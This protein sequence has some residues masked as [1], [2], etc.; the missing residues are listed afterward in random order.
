MMNEDYSMSLFLPPIGPVREGGR[1]V[2]GASMVPEMTTGLEYVY[3]LIRYDEGL[4]RQTDAVRRAADAGNGKLCRCLKAATL[5]YVTPC[6]VFSRR[7]SD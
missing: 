1:T 7:R 2:K 5:P 3:R 6:G 4:A